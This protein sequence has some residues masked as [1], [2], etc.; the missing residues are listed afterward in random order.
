[1]CPVV[2]SG[3][4]SLHIPAILAICCH[5]LNWNAGMVWLKANFIFLGVKVSVVLSGLCNTWKQG[6]C[7]DILVMLLNFCTEMGMRSQR[8]IGEKLFFPFS[9]C[10][11][12]WARKGVSGFKKIIACLESLGSH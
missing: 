8:V 7:L 12:L 2:C 5:T 1:M 10:D 3:E 9:E 4:I 11:L 6:F